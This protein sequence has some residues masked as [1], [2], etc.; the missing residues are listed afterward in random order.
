MF[1]VSAVEIFAFQLLCV[2]YSAGAMISA[3]VAR[4]EGRQHHGRAERRRNGGETLIRE[5]VE[6]R[7]AAHTETEETETAH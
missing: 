7:L 4:R 3:D 2:A 5:I 6:D 1:R